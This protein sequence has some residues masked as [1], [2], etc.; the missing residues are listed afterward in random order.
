ML[1]LQNLAD[2]LDVRSFVFIFFRLLLQSLIFLFLLIACIWLISLFCQDLHAFGFRN[3]LTRR[4]T[5]S[6][7]EGEDETVAVP[8]SQLP[9][10]DSC[11]LCLCAIPLYEAGLEAS[12]ASAKAIARRV[13]SGDEEISILMVRQ[14][15]TIMHIVIKEA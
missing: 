14:V 4:G 8:I 5:A 1:S 11:R 13:C 12:E 2:F 9:L 15:Q 6:S 7:S 10:S 3:D